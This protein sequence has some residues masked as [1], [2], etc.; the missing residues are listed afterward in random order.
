MREKKFTV[1]GSEQQFQQMAKRVAEANKKSPFEQKAMG[2]L[3]GLYKQATS[4]D[5]PVEQAPWQMLNPTGYS[6][7][8]AWNKYKGMSKEEAQ[9][10]YID[11]AKTLLD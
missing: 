6:K 3:Y 10:R 8:E 1:M 5:N 4:G 11:F 7:W 2:Q 9:R